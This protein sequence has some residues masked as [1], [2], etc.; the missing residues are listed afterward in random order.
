[1]GGGDFFGGIALIAEG[2]R[3]ATATTESDSKLLVL[4]HREFHSLMD[5]FPAIRTCVLEA[6]AKRIRRLK[7]ESAN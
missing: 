4:G 5:Q 6:L 2:P 7:P 1:M 3:T